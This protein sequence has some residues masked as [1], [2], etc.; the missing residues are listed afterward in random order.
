[1]S[2]YVFSKRSIRYPMFEAFDQP[3]LVSSVGRRNRTTIAPQALILMN[4][5]MIA[6]QAGHF[7]ERVRAEAGDDIEAQVERAIELALGR[8][9]RP[10]ELGNGVEF[11][12]ENAD[13]LAAF[14]HL[15]FNLNE[16]LYR[17]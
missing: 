16:F 11:V 13:G 1:R 10:A 4:N 8:P 3:G 5:P 14:C 6:F 9:P 7:A 12:S 2:L 17:P 15:L